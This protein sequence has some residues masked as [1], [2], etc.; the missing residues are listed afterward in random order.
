MRLDFRKNCLIDYGGE[1]ANPKQPIPSYHSSSPQKKTPN[2][3]QQ[4]RYHESSLNYVAD[5]HPDTRCTSCQIH[6]IR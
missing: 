3:H 2:F 4:A 6:V 1:A 5:I